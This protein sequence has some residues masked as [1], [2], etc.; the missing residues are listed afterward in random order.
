MQEV[1]PRTLV[2]L[3]YSIK[4]LQQNLIV[5]EGLDFNVRLGSAKKD[6]AFANF[7]LDSQNSS[8][9]CLI[10]QIYGLLL[11]DTTFSCTMR[12]R[13][14]F[15]P[16][17][18]PHNLVCKCGSKISPNLLLNCKHFITFRSKVHDAVRDQLYCMSKPHRIVSYLKPLLSRFVDGDTLNTWS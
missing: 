6:P 4:K 18:V 2:N 15:W 10:S 12:L 14:L 5:C 13:W 8:S 11:D 17:N 1:Q 3:R 7:M 16:N 9:S